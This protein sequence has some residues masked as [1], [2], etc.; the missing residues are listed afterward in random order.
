MV[1]LLLLAI[2]AIVWS[3]SQLRSSKRAQAKLQRELELLEQRYK[4]IVDVDQEVD[5]AK[6]RL[7]E[8]MVQHGRIEAE[9]ESAK[10]G[11]TRIH[12]ELALANDAAF[13][14]EIGYYE[15]R[16]DFEDL[17]SYEAELQRIREK[18]KAMLREDGTGDNRRA[19]A[20]AT[21]SL[22]FN[23]SATQGRAAQKKTIKLILRAFNGESDS[24]IA[25]VS[26]RNAEAME[27]RIR[28][29]FDAINAITQKYDFCEL[30]PRYL[31]LRVQELQLV[32]EWEEAKQRE[33]EEQA[34]VREQM[35]DEEKAA[36]E[37]EKAQQQ[38]DKEESK[39]QEL[40][41]KAEQEVLIASEKDKAKLNSKIEELQQRIAEIEEKKRAISQ[42]MLTKT[43]HVYIISNVGSFGENIYKIGMTR[44]LEPMDRV[45]E[46]GD[47]SVPFP[48]DVH[49]MIRTS[50]APSLENALHKHFNQR[51]LN[52]E[53]E[54][55]EFFRVSIDEIRQELDQLRNNL[56][57]DS[58]LRL[59]LLAEAKEYRMSEAKRKHL[60]TS[61]NQ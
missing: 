49:A 5:R 41:Q 37:A 11:L 10:R 4:P 6:E 36:R 14:V 51:R 35:R 28:S 8:L 46:L 16:Y 53:N 38:A 19:A 9:I 58:E 1:L 25:R 33:K 42:A 30:N 13:L 22:S 29:A 2:A 55:K 23:G 15:P 20:F 48:F 45:K 32:Y 52:L 7:S 3:I 47:A 39:Y 34:K 26:Y 60:E 54:R 12:E 21:Q 43:G 50:D 56:G 24:F 31:D 18:Q 59:T 44:R 17:P 27:K 57:I 61:W 40:L